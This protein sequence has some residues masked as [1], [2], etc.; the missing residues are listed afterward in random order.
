LASLALAAVFAKFQLQQDIP[1]MATD[2]QYALDG[3]YLVWIY[4]VYL[5]GC[6]V[7]FGSLGKLAWRYSS[8]TAIRLRSRLSRE[9]A[10]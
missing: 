4:G 1:R 6:L 5:A 10:T 3:W 8:Q 2:E 9:A 7:L